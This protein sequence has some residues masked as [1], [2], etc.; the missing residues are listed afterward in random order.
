MHIVSISEYHH[1]L[2]DVDRLCTEPIQVSIP[3]VC[4]SLVTVQK[5]FAEWL[6]P[7][8]LPSSR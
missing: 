3:L 4:D 5:M 8:L 2:V 6:F 1:V 7:L